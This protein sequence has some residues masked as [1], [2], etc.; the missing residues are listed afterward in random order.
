MNSFRPSRRVR[1]A[2]TKPLNTLGPPLACLLVV[3]LIWE[4]S[5]RVGGIDRYLLP[6]PGDVG[7]VL[8]GRSGPL[9]AASGQTLFSAMTGFLASL[10]VGLVV[11]IFFAEFRWLRVSAYPYA[12]FLHTVPIVAISPLIITWFG[13][14]NQSVIVITFIVSLFPIITGATN[15]LLG[16][17]PELGELFRLYR[18]SRWQTLWKLKLPSA[19]PQIVT[20]A[21][22]ASGLAIVGA[23]VG[24][25]FAGYEP[26]QYGLGYYIFAA[27]GQFR[28]DILLAAVILSTVLGIA[29][30][31]AVSLVGKVCLGRWMHP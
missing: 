23:I 16:A 15:G 6:T 19:V 30:F 22:T 12:I 2:I 5:I 27:Q 18:A 21:Q 8:L 31:V 17:S 26:G 28:T 4:L 3:I 25:F 14:G 29:L 24:E 10:G 9:L 11:A 20:G 7:L 13:Y 1:E